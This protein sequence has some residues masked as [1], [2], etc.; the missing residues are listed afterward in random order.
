MIESSR[1][2]LLLIGVVG[3][4]FGV[5]G[6]SSELDPTDP[7]DAYIM[8]RDAM[9]AGDAEAVWGRL[10]PQTHEYFE[11]SHSHLQEMGETIERYLPQADHRL[12]KRQ[13]GVILLREVDDGKSLFLRVFQPD[14]L[15]K[16]EA[17]V[18]GSNVRELA[19]AEDQ[20]TAKVITRSGQEFFLTK[21]RDGQ[22]Y[23]MLLESSKELNAAMAWVE[24]NKTALGQTVDDLIAE[25]RTRREKVI[26]ELMNL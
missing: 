1:R 23:V 3:L 15:P 5:S 13:S 8:F 24:A 19:L 2:L 21:G 7:N 4:A 16:E 14:Q 9:M 11:H 22:W 10:D 25:E 20:K 26:A 18:L 12:A 17:F 6:C